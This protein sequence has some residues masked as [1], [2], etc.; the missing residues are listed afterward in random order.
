MAFNVCV[1]VVL[2][3]KVFVGMCFFRKQSRR[4]LRIYYIIRIAIDALIYMPL[5]FI[6]RV[7]TA[8]YTINYFLAGGILFISE[9]LVMIVYRKDLIRK[10]EVEKL[11]DVTGSKVSQITKNKRNILI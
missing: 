5:L 8:T 3:A 2:L 1:S 7:F 4:S 10:S 11:E 9:L 6:F